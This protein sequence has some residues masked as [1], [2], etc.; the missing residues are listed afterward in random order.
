MSDKG[1]KKTLGIMGGMGAMAGASFYRRLV[2][3]TPAE[4]DQEHIRAVLYC[5][6]GVPDRT[7][8]ILGRGED[9]YPALLDSARILE[10]AG[11]ELIVMACVSAHYYIDSLRRDIET[12]ILSALEETA[13][14]IKEDCPDGCRLGLMA[15][16]GTLRSNLF[17]PLLDGY[18]ILTLPDD[19]QESLVMGAIYGELKAGRIT[20][21]REKAV[22]ALD[23]LRDMGAEAVIIGCSE[24]PLVIDRRSAGIP[25]FDTME[26][27]IRKAVSLCSG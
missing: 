4:N 16:T 11:S 14:A 13:E 20:A 1:S 26:I 3:S 8:A 5:N 6:P 18:H 27:L 10:G 19:L 7:E 22:E 2:E 23:I 25:V 12:D 24:L 9:P 17:Q 21:G 15:T